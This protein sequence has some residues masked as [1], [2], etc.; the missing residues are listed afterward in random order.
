M[1]RLIVANMVTVD[2]FF[3][4]P[5]DEIDWHN[6]DEEFN[7]YATAFLDTLDTLVFGRKTYELMASW[8]PTVGAVEDDPLVAARMNALAK[9]VFSHTLERV[10]WENSRLVKD[11]IAGAMTAMKQQDGKDM[12]IFGSGSVV[13]QLAAQGVIDEYRVIV[14]PLALGE[15]RS[16]FG[17]L[18]QRVPL[19]L[20]GTKAFRS[21]NVLLRYEP[22]R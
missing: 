5:K 4:G 16:Q 14:N 22:A 7:D 12:A 11:D 18:R 21:G 10:D 2:G 13:G 6:V 15:G 19:K 17:G 8:W 1:R 3:A 9:V 20:A